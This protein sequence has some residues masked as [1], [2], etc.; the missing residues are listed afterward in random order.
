MD[1]SVRTCGGAQMNKQKTIGLT[2]FLKGSSNPKDDMPGCAS[3]D[4]QQNTCCFDHECY[5]L[6]GQRCSWFEKAVLPTAKQIGLLQH[7]VTAYSK[8]VGLSGELDHLCTYENVRVC[9]DCGGPLQPKQR[10]CDTCTMRRR[11]QTY[12]RSR[13]KRNS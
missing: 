11:K 1:W 12:R 3:F 13:S 6:E 9:P 5:V 10:Y 4:I 2:A 8:K 7:I